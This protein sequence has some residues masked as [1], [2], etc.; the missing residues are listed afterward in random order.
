MLVALRLSLL[1]VDFHANPDE[2]AC[3]I[4]GH[5]FAATFPY[6]SASLLRETN[7]RDRRLIP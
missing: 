6:V 3:G 7:P 5:P 1:R 2:S 4:C